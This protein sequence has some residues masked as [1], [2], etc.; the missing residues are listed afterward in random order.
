MEE[1]YR[2]F[3]RCYPE[4]K[5]SIYKDF[6]RWVLNSDPICEIFRRGWKAGRDSIKDNELSIVSI[7]DY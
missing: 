3:C 6:E 1:C 5:E 2:Y 4:L 7:E